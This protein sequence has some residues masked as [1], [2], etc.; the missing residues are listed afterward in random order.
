MT[1]IDEKALEKAESVACVLQ[2][3][4]K[5][6]VR[7]IIMMYESAKASQQPDVE[8]LIAEIEKKKQSAGGSQMF[9]VLMQIAAYND[10]V[11][12]CIN[13]IRKWTKGEV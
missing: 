13:T 4:G 6:N 2:L 9:E 10:A 8:A 1:K 11:D 12:D 3:T 7:E 5:I